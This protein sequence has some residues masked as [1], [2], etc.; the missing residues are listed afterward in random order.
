MIACLGG[1]VHGACRAVGLAVPALLSTVEPGLARP[2]QPGRAF[3]DC[4]ATTCPEMVVIPAGAFTMGAAGGEEGRPE[5]APHPVRIARPFAIGVREV[6]NREYTRFIVET[7]YRPSTGCRS[8][9]R[10]TDTVAVRPE[11]DF[12]YPGAGAGD[13]APSMPAVCI[14]WNDARAYVAWL[15]KR[16]GKPYR[17]PSEAEWEFAARA[18]SQAEYPWG[19]KAEAGC[20]M[21]NTLDRTGAASGVLAAFGRTPDAG[22]PVVV[23]AACDDGHAGA[24][25]VGSY[26]ANAFGVHDMIGNVWEWTED[27]YVAPYPADA[28]TDG[29]AYQVAGTC[30]RR[31]VRG[32]S[33]ITVPFR[34]RV[35]WR[36][37]D[38]EDLVSW[39]FGFRIA[40]DLTAEGK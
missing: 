35:A 25:P 28:P 33:W 37:R 3:R 18:G 15:A 16:T 1:K 30:P 12:R 31:A 26:R 23:E 8:Y 14:A 32:G 29:R 38:P 11:A 22:R 34:N 17:L 39:I 4:A 5:G 10:A 27:C 9:D 40:R 2:L 24:A 6:S 21:A 20:G 7:G 36:G 13:G 19:D